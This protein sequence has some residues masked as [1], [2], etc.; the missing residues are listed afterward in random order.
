MNADDDSSTMAVLW[1]IS[2]LSAGTHTLNA[3]LVGHGQ[4]GGVYMDLVNF[5]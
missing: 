3:S 1:S 5:E 4:D 2:G